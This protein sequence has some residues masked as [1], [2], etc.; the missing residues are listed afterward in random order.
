MADKLAVSGQVLSPGK[1]AEF[2]ASIEE[3]RAT[4]AKI[5]TQLGI[6]RAE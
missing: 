2:E 5:A 4:V 6:K 3:Q 1:A